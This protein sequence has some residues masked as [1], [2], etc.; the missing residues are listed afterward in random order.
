M[1]THFALLSLSSISRCKV[2]NL[3]FFCGNYS[4]GLET[5]Q[6]SVGSNLEV[7]I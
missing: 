3:F 7:L 5:L 1:L 2:K 6:T 4:A